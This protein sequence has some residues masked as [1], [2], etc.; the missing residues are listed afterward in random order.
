MISMSNEQRTALKQAIRSAIRAKGETPFGIGQ[1][2]RDQLIQQAQALNL[3]VASIVA[4]AVTSPHSAI[5]AAHIA[6]EAEAGEAQATLDAAALTAEAQAELDGILSAWD[7]MSPK[8]FRERIAGLVARAHKPAQVIERE[9]VVMLDSTNSHVPTENLAQPQATRSGSIAFGKLLGLPAEHASY[10]APVA[11]WTG[12]IN[13][14]DVAPDHVWPADVDG[15]SAALLRQRPVYLTGPKGVGK[16]TTCEQLAARLGRPFVV[17]SCS[18]ET[19]LPELVGT[20]V[21]HDGRVRFQHG[22][23]TAAMQMAGCVILLDEVDTL[24]Q[25]VA[26]GLNGILENRCYVV[27]QTG[28]KITC[29]DG[30]LFF[31]AGNSNGRG[32]TTG[33]YAG[34]QEQNAA[35]MSRF[36][37]MVAVTYLTPAR[38][39]RLLASRSGC[40]RELA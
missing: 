3:D 17:I 35:L 18:E 2:T 5:A 1:M 6:S 16:T 21:P 24:R 38:E 7:D 36:R 13:V 39:A 27:P 14:P 19:E 28:E 37:S 26:P 34:V 12:G 4:G 30:V 10:N 22:A 20:T 32:D 15:F 11:L 25:G 33:R 8:A 40:T 9:R 23:L 31:G 29:A